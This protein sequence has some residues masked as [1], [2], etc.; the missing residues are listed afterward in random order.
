[1]GLLFRDILYEIQYTDDGMIETLF[2]LGREPELSVAELEAL[3]K[4]WT[5]TLHVVSAA[6]ALLRHSEPLA[7]RALDHLGGSIKQISLRERWLIVGSAR[8]TVNDHLTA[9]WLQELFPG[10][11]RIEFGISWYDAPPV[12]RQAAQGS[13][14]RLKKEL[15]ATKRPVRFVISKEPQLSAVTIQR[16][17]LNKKGKEIVFVTVGQEILVGV[18]TAVQDYQRYGLRDFGRPAANV[19]SGMLPP[20][21]AQ[22][23]LNIASIGPNDVLLDP[24]CGSGTLLQEAV[25]MGVRRIHGSDSESR[26]VK[27]SQENLRWLVKEFSNLHTDID[28]LMRDARQISVN[29]DAIVTEPYLGKPLRG[30]EPREWLE[31]QAR[32]LSRLYLQCFQQWSKHLRPGGR[33]VMIWPEF[34]VGQSDVTLSLD[35]AIIG[36]GFEQRSLLSVAAAAALGITD[37]TVLVYGRDDARVRRQIRKWER[38]NKRG[39]S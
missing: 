9:E 24:F 26:A 8:Q 29:P 1:M 20:K 36:L 15:A 4:S 16:N 18:T 34:V 38:R 22:M 10:N 27:D 2:I 19:K 14:L 32:E 39:R 5:G 11:G 12:D 25:L 23:M 7:E 33:V 30:H 35:R 28:I 3:A 37:P 17:G 21:L 6:G 13:G 31:Q